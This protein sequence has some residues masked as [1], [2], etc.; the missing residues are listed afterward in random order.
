MFHHPETPSHSGSGSISSNTTRGDD[1][2]TGMTICSARIWR[3]QKNE[4]RLWETMRHAYVGRQRSQRSSLNHLA[5][6]Q[7][8]GS[9]TKESH[10][11]LIGNSWSK[12]EE[13]ERKEG[14]SLSVLLQSNPLGHVCIG[15][16]FGVQIIVLKHQRRL[17]PAEMF[18]CVRVSKPL[19]P[20]IVFSHHLGVPCS[21]ATP[22]KS[23]QYRRV[24]SQC[25]HWNMPATGES[26]VNCVAEQLKSFSLP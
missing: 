24:R 20:T 3:S 4:V 21:P 12:E 17:A 15:S 7:H 22:R 1:L 25:S 8:W 6:E 2:S 19:G 10:T 26:Y 9:V 11:D 14:V 5:K 23:D 18:I 16:G 13:E